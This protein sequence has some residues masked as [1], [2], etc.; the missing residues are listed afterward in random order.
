M[1]VSRGSTHEQ[2][3]GKSIKQKY[4]VQRIFNRDLQLNPSNLQSLS[5]SVTDTHSLEES[6]FSITFVL[7]GKEDYPIFFLFYQKR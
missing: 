7:T 3:N 2:A 4:T 6:I 5:K 1:G